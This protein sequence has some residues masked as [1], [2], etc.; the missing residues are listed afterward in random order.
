MVLVGQR[1][2][3]GPQGITGPVDSYVRTFNGLTG[4]LE[5]VSSVSGGTGIG[6]SGATGAITIRNTGVLTFNG[7]TGDVTGVTTGTPNNFIALQTFSSGISAS[8]GITF[9]ND[10]FVNGLRIGRGSTSGAASNI[11]IGNGGS[12]TP[13][14]SNISGTVNVAIGSFALS[15]T[16]NGIGNIA[17]GEVALNALRN[18]NLN[19]GIG[20]A[21]L[22]FLTSGQGNIGIGYRAIDSGTSASSNIALGNQSL[23]H[24]VTGSNN[25]VIG[26]SSGNRT[27]SSP[28]ANNTNPN[29]AIYIG[30]DIRPAS[31]TGTNEIII[32]HNARG[33]ASNSTV[34]GTPTQTLATIYGLLNVPS[35]ISGYNQF[36]LN[37]LTGT[38]NI[39]A[40]SNMGVTVDGNSIRLS[41]SGSAGLSGPIILDNSIY[42]TG[43]CNS[44]RISINTSTDDVTLYGAQK[45]IAGGTTPSVTS[46]GII[47][48][49]VAQSITFAA[50]NI[51]FTGNVTF[52]RGNLV[53]SFNGATGNIL[54][55][56]SINTGSGLTLSGAS[57][58]NV[59]IS[60][61]GVR[62]LTGTSNQITI[63]PTSGTGEI[64]ASLPTT[65]NGV[66][67]LLGVNSIISEE[68]ANLTITHNSSTPSGSASITLS[69]SA[70]TT[71]QPLTV[72]GNLTV[73]GTYNGNI[74]RSF[75]GKTGAIQGV[76]AARGGTGISIS[77]SGGTGT[78]TINNTGVLSF[79]GFTGNIE[80]IRR[81]NGL[82]GTVALVG[83]TG[84]TVVTSGAQISVGMTN[85]I[86]GPTGAT[87]AYGL[88]SGMF[89][90]YATFGS[91]IICETDAG[92][93]QGIFYYVLCPSNDCT[94][95][96]SSLNSARGL[97][98]SGTDKYGVDISSY[99][100]DLET[101][102][103]LTGYLFIRYY[104]S[105]PNRANFLKM[106]NVT[107]L[108]VTDNGD[109]T[110]K[111]IVFD[112]EL[113]GSS[114]MPTSGD[115]YAI[116]YQPV[117]FF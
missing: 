37:G 27:I 22:Q 98:L 81:L 29:N 80:G 21:S 109:S 50:Q 89:F 42:I 70:I 2:D 43:V 45:L 16:T 6:V 33:I 105:D 26:I 14:K 67:S 100:E 23:F 103:A 53:N 17:I 19:I 69:P 57:T 47:I 94:C 39:V 48:D 8:G 83:G 84:I 111:N 66:N 4:D 96:N 34:I 35:G 68:D 7:L 51:G 73:T 101:A 78:V 5:G 11:A 18:G 106:A 41:S 64:V 72:A 112:I 54:G 31:A 90:E 56:N 87:G 82:T 110:R 44:S 107:N 13:L 108:K 3:T 115:I 15:G 62:Q 9:G 20:Y 46:P 71:N 85:L 36:T 86:A 93:T 25:I 114:A 30:S 10:I 59:T 60:N 113:I 91:G 55:V 24:S 74:V 61:I 97:I 75:N 99:F 58:G 104:N 28:P 117:F 88:N 76:S 102:G 79:N 40:G 1:G 77:P 38:V 95:I 63:T 116:I 92:F 52:I 32:G 49:Q 65:I 12:N